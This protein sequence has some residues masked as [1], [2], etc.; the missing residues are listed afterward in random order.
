MDF[1]QTIHD[2]LNEYLGK[3]RRSLPRSDG[4]I[5][6][7]AFVT[8]RVTDI[9]FG[10]LPCLFLK[11]YSQLSSQVISTPRSPN[12]VPSMSSLALKTF[13][14]S[15]PSSLSEIPNFPHLRYRWRA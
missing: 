12:S 3:V 15:M 6:S 14:S 4:A 8:T 10:G 2:Q 9:P 7:H 11:L 1:L 13:S 5:V